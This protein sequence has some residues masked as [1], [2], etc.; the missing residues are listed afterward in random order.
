MTTYSYLTGPTPEPAENAPAITIIDRL[1][2]EIGDTNVANGGKD[3]VFSNEEYKMIME[4]E[5]GDLEDLSRGNIINLTVARLYEV[6]AGNT[7]LFVGKQS[8]LNNFTDGTATSVEL[9]KLA[10][11]RRALVV[12]VI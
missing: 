12:I 2:L 10:S 7:A 9:M 5:V 11:E 3:A 1:R 4:E 8:F 6:L